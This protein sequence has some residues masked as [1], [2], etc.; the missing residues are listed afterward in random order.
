MHLSSSRIIKC[1]SILATAW[2]LSSCALIYQDSNC[3]DDITSELTVRNEWDMSPDANP[4]GMSFVFF[5]PKEDYPW[6]FDFANKYGGS[7]DIPCG[8][9]G[10]ITY[11]ND[12]KSI[13]TVNEYNYSSFTMITPPS[14]LYNGLGAVAGEILGE[15]TFNDEPVRK[16]PDKIWCDAVQHLQFDPTRTIWTTDSGKEVSMSP[17]ELIMHPQQQTATITVTV[18]HVSNIVSIKRMCAWLSGLPGEL[19][20]ASISTESNHV[21]HPF[22]IYKDGD[23]RL[24]G[25]L[26]SFGSADNITSTNTLCL[27]FWLKDGSE[28]QCEFNVTDD[29][30]ASPDPFNIH[31]I[32]DKID[33]PLVE[34]D[35]DGGGFDVSVDGWPT[36]EID[37]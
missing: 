11:N 4:D 36:I 17:P 15:T 32:I 31:I 34:G 14:G 2:S 28:K 37:L 3:P 25:T 7:V 6:R 26:N 8:N 21:T 18:L 35:Q 9:Y 13:I 23:N 1:T 16:F 19:R 22:S 30:K 24:V 27:K 29:I 5:D 33:L 12:L 20:P 10:V